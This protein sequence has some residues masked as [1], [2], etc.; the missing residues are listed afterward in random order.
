M[1]QD[2]PPIPVSRQTVIR[3]L[4]DK[5]PT[6]EI[7]DRLLQESVLLTKEEDLPSDIQS[8]L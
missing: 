6:Q 2:D 8:Y 3:R 5:V 1:N 7:R 4:G